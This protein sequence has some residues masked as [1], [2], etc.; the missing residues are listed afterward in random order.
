MGVV[1]AGFIQYRT[2][3]HITH[4]C[5]DSS[6]RPLCVA[7]TSYMTTSVICTFHDHLL[8]FYSRRCWRGLREP[9]STPTLCGGYIRGATV[10][11]VFIG[12]HPRS[13]ETYISKQHM[14]TMSTSLVAVFLLVGAA[15]AVVHVGLYNYMQFI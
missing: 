14:I 13:F 5:N 1:Y 11:W 15:I 8:L 3:A 12:Q 6:L 7:C 10:G 9:R 2:Q 4:M